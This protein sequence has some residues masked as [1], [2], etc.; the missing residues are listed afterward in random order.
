MNFETLEQ[1]VLRW[2]EARKIIPNSSPNVQ[3]LK[4][5]SELGELADATIKGNDDEIADG[6]GD[7]LVTLIIYCALQNIDPIVCLA[8][9]YDTIKG[10]K[11]VLTPEGVFIKEATHV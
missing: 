2:A 7:V 10:R 6:V 3:L 9:A 4:T 11:G 5:V 8:S 1:D